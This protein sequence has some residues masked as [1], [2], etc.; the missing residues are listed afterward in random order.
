MR[1]RWRKPGQP[2]AAQWLSRDTHDA[3][4]DPRPE[5]GEVGPGLRAHIPKSALAAKTLVQ[6]GISSMVVDRAAGGWCSGRACLGLAPVLVAA[7]GVELIVDVGDGVD[8]GDVSVGAAGLDVAS[9]ACPG[10]AAPDGGGPAHRPHV[11][12]ATVGDDPDRWGLPGAS[13]PPSVVIS[14]S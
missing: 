4:C 7:D 5:T 6:R 2:G 14:S 3:D 12:V 11:E 1:G 9:V 10:A 13:S 8:E